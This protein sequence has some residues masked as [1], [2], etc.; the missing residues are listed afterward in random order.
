[1]ALFGAI[2]IIIPISIMATIMGQHVSLYTTS[3][4][5]GIFGFILA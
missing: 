3:I 5:T 4:A 1:M 2:A